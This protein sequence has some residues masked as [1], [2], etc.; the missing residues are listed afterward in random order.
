MS[1]NRKSK[2]IPLKPVQ[3]SPEKYIKT[4]ARSLPVYECLI[5]DDWQ[6]TGICSIIIARQHVTGNITF[7]LYLVDIYCL[8]LKDVFYQCNVDPDD[9]EDKKPSQFNWEECEYTLA[10]NIIYGAIAYAEDYGFKPH[11]DFT[12]AQ[13]ILEEDDEAVELMEIEF[14]FKG[15]PFYVQGLNDSTAKINNIKSTLLRTAGEGNFK[16]LLDLD[17]DMDFDDDE[18]YDDDDD[19]SDNLEEESI[20]T[21]K[22]LIQINKVYD[23]LIRTPKVKALIEEPF[24]GV[25]YKLSEKPVLNQYRK[26]DNDEQQERYLMLIDIVNNAAYDQAEMGIKDAIKEY[27]GKPQFYNLLQTVYH[28]SEQF[29][30]SDT[31]IIEM[32]NRFP[33]YLFAKVS[34]ANFLINNS[35]HEGVLE[36]FNGKPDLGYLY[37]GQKEFNTHEAAI[38]YATMCRYFIADDNI[39][40]A[41][42]YMNAILKNDLDKVP[43]QTLVKAAMMQLGEAK[44]AIIK[45]KEL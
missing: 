40:S 25:N 26:F 33:D 24:I 14:G 3:L 10:H 37:P 29:D 32:Y 35:R 20:E 15:M 28:F 43:G 6:S 9:Y 2:I 11:K 16:L 12:I 34:Y 30:K 4:Q 41:D 22:L 21:V 19:L 27:P 23:E 31:I 8:G 39:D 45:S 36:V 42:I 17:D 38:Y 13:F 5:N 44:M 18:W 1:K 7:G